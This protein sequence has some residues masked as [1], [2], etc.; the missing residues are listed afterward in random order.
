MVGEQENV[1]KPAHFRFYTQKIT[2]VFPV[3]RSLIM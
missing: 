1:V 3:E 2:V